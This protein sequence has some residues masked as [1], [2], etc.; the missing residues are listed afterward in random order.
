MPSIELGEELIALLVHDV[1]VV[2]R[3]CVNVLYKQAVL[4]RELLLI[5]IWTRCDEVCAISQAVKG[6]KDGVFFEISTV[7]KSQAV[8]CLDLGVDEDLFLNELFFLAK[9][10]FTDI[11]RLVFYVL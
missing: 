9:F 8:L 11:F 10:H 5:S 6:F 4:L 2:F 7:W 3:K 1:I